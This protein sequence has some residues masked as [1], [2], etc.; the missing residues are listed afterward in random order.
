MSRF[1]ILSADYQPHIGGKASHITNLTRGLTQIGHEVQ[2][3]SR[4]D[5]HKWLDVL[6]IRAPGYTLKRLLGS[7]AGDLPFW[8][9]YRLTQ[10]FFARIVQSHLVGRNRF[11]VISAQDIMSANVLDG[12]SSTHSC[13]IVLTV[14]GDQTN[15][16]VS[17]GLV[18]RGSPVERWFWAQEKQA[19]SHVDRILT[20]D[21]RLRTHV[22]TVLK[23]DDPHSIKVDV[24]HNFVDVEQ[25]RPLP[26]YLR[27]D[28]KRRWGL[29]ETMFVLL[30]PRRLTPKNGVV[31]AVEALS[32]LPQKTEAGN[33][34]VLLLT[35]E[36]ADRQRI[37]VVIEGKKLGNRIRFLGNIDHSRMPELYAVADIVL[38][39]SVPHAGVVEATSLSAL[40][41]MACGTPVVASAIGGLSEI[42]ETGRTGL[43]V[44]PGDPK[45]IADSISIL[46]KDKDYRMNLAIDGRTVVLDHHSHLRAA[47]RFSRLCSDG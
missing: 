11:D 8:L 4:S 39:P 21:S 24:M 9:H 2:T 34:I 7:R 41:A 3:I 23:S 27:S 32:L 30:C 12:L 13:P 45:A 22:V 42:I 46:A 1:L 16:L 44:P 15:E 6:L 28:L 14:H 36:G 40:E 37:E 35:G 26:Q 18:K 38:I 33:L 10:V 25:F 20:V 5:V 43:L 31:H 47:D 19:Y 29:D 17:A